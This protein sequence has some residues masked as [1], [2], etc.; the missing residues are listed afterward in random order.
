ML[1]KSIE[2]FSLKVPLHTPFKTAVREVSHIHDIV[3]V[4]TSEDGQLGYG[5]APSTPQITGDDH[6]SIAK[7][8]NEVLS[9]LLLNQSITYIS[10]LLRQV[11]QAKDAGSNAKA[12]VDI[13]LFDLYAKYCDAPLYKILADEA[14]F[15][16]GVDQYKQNKQGK[17]AQNAASDH[18]ASS[19]Y[20]VLETDYTISVN[21]TEQMC[22]DIA[23]AI[24]R[25]YR[26][27]KI[28]IGSQPAEDVKRL[29]AIY[30]YVES[31]NAEARTNAE[32][33]LHLNDC[34]R[35]ITLRLD[36]NQGWDCQTT[37]DI[38]GELE[39]NNIHFEL[40]EQPV[41]A[42]DTQGLIKIK[43][44][45]KTPVMADESA[46]DLAQVKSLIKANAVDII[47]IKL[48]KAGGL[49][50]A[51]EIAR[52]CKNHQVP[53]MIG[54]ML[55][56]S[57]GVAAAAHLGFA[58]SD[59]I[60]FVDLDG[61]TLGQYD[62]IAQSS[63]SQT[64]VFDDAVITLNQSAGLGINIQ[65]NCTGLTRWPLSSSSKLAQETSN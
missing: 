52:Y 6:E 34:A 59:T 45:I 12:A 3:V 11:H 63:M 27:L 8:I 39:A 54:C 7:A 18:L 46:F 9:P 31:L 58:F 29:R 56:G 51:I 17:S 55:E 61:P 19:T 42:N 24:A 15:G 16:T 26:C 33:N 38:M 50:P 48:M 23:K 28:K 4:L 62:P 13:A 22:E 57:I 10:S 2:L 44:S 35:A 30:E 14:F 60:K 64:T 47:N 1:I 37:I 65:G 49:L 32:A 21:D 36:V 25:G 43:Q 40:V 5:S 41:K 20:P 53:C